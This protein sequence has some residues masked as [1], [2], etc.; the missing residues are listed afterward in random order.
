MI[1]KTRIPSQASRYW[2]K[3]LEARDVKALEH[4]ESTEGK[5]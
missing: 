2:D 3:N 1:K 5:Y 4:L